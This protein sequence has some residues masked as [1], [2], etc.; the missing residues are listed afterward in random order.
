MGLSNAERQQRWRERQKA[1]LKAD[2]EALK[3]RIRELEAENLRLK[4]EGRKRLEEA[5]KPFAAQIAALEAE[6]AKWK[7]LAQ[8]RQRRLTV[9]K[10]LRPDTPVFMSRRS[11]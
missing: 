7:K 2:L 8:D 4:A 11:V 6:V 10:T 3:T 1:N 5:K 9:I